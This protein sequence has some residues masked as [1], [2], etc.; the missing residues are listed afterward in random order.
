MKK[1]NLRDINVETKLKCYNE[2][3]TLK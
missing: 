2:I 3:Q 1:I